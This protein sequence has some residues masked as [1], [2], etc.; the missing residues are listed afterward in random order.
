MCEFEGLVGEDT[1]GWGDGSDFERP[2]VLEAALSTGVIVVLACAEPLEYLCAEPDA[3][4]DCARLTAP[5]GVIED[6]CC[7]VDATSDEVDGAGA[8]V[9]VGRAGASSW[10]NGTRSLLREAAKKYPVSVS[11]SQ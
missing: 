4:D 8:G 6:A 5:D 10:G 7:C 9:V 1:P 2:T 3:E 11:F